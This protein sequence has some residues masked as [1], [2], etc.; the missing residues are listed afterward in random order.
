MTN[1][2]IYLFFTF[3]T[4]ELLK[5][6]TTTNPCFEYVNC[7][8]ENGCS[9]GVENKDA[10]G[11]TSKTQ[12]RI[13]NGKPSWEHR[14]PWMVQIQRT[15]LLVAIP[16]MPEMK[17][18]S[19]GGGSIITKTAIITA[20]HNLCVDR[21]QG[22]DDAGGGRRYHIT[23]PERGS[24]TQQEWDNVRQRNL[25]QENLNEIM[26]WIGTS[27]YS[28]PR[29]STYNKDVQAYL[30]DYHPN[31]LFS[32]N[33]DVGVIISKAEFAFDGKVNRIC[34]P[35]E[36]NEEE[37]TKKKR[38][39]DEKKK[40]KLIVTTA[41]W[42]RHF[43]TTYLPPNVISQTT[44]HTNEGRA[45]NDIQL[46]PA[47]DQRLRFLDCA[48][49]AADDQFCY[50]WIPKRGIETLSARIDLFDIQTTISTIDEKYSAIKG[51]EDQ[52]ECEKYFRRAQAAWCRAG[53]TM[54]EFHQTIDRIIIQRYGESYVTICYNMIKVARYGFCLTNEPAPRNWGFCSRSCEYFPWALTVGTEITHI[55]NKPY[56]VTKFK[57]FEDFPFDQ[58]TLQNRFA[59]TLT[60]VGIL[61]AFK[62]ISP[63]LPRATNAVFRETNNN[64]FLEYL[65]DVY[66]APRPD[67]ESGHIRTAPGDSGSPLWM[68]E[69]VK[70]K[71]INRIVGIVYG[72][73][74]PA[75]LPLNIG[76]TDDPLYK[77]VGLVSKITKEI[78]E[79]VY[80]KSYDEV[81]DP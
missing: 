46:P 24:L 29:T 70:G 75:G 53:K 62:C 35:T 66:D 48:Q 6:C 17:L 12:S 49:N 9:C 76:Y 60:G 32:S 45:S 77:C 21:D 31:A 28:G 59:P 34:P 47:F 39:N 10:K 57:Y 23:C 16:L 13:I 26:F 20:G 2:L 25:N 27:I 38:N 69:T 37:E 42:G 58:N 50:D 41:G 36:N 44:C 72:E 63:V 43:T 3:C 64:G 30:Y 68:T 73:L 22:R 8:P 61:D 51:R 67:R 56:E 5:T 78:M 55:Y 33:G 54:P 81:V 18:P 7:D 19:I 65:H 40:E 71:E 80:S 15:T 79:W 74:S 52:I 14:Y 1:K 11:N 4:F